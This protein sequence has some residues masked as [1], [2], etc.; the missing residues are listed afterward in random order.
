MGQIIHGDCLDVLPTL[1]AASVDL[2][3][4]DLPYGTTQCAWDAIIPFAKLW[5]ELLRIAKP[6][7]A[8]VF[9]ATQPFTTALIGSQLSLFKYSWHWDKVNGIRNHLNA[10][11]QPMR[12][13]EDVVVFYREQ[14]TYNPQMR[15]GGYLSRKTKP[16]QSDGF[17]TVTGVDV[18]RHINQLYPTDLLQIKSHDP[19]NSVHPT[20][21]PVELFRYLIRTYTNDGATILDCCAGVGTAAIAASMEGRHSICIEREAKY[22]DLAHKRISDLG[23]TDMWSKPFDRQDLLTD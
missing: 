14:C 18:G 16:G 23:W 5:P 12:Q 11:R 9:T 21:K 3:L 7:A 13:M 20:Q 2:V 17:G 15:E 6:R 10:K 4:T 1:P 22:V 19:N 8:L